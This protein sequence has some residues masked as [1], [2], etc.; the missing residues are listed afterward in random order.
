MNL[1]ENSNV[2]DSNDDTTSILSPLLEDVS[3]LF[4]PP[5]SSILVMVYRQYWSTFK[6]VFILILLHEKGIYCFKCGAEIINVRMNSA[7]WCVH[8]RTHIHNVLGAEIEI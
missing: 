5:E 4:K 1:R 3:L 2:Q 6:L 8:T 7:F